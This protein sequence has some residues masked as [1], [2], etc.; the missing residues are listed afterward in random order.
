MWGG[1]RGRICGGGPCRRRRSPALSTGRLQRTPSCSW[2]AMVSVWVRG[3][4]RPT[5]LPSGRSSSRT[6]FP[7]ASSSRG[8]GCQRQQG[9]AG[10][11]HPLHVSPMKSTASAS[12]GRP[13][14][15]GGSRCA[16]STKPLCHSARS[17]RSPDEAPAAAAGA[18]PDAGAEPAGPC[19]AAWTGNSPAEPSSSSPWQT[20]ADSCR[21]NTC[22]T[23]KAPGPFVRNPGP[24][25]PAPERFSPVHSA[26]GG[27]GSRPAGTGRPT[28]PSRREGPAAPG[29]SGPLTAPPSPGWTTLAAL[30][31]TRT[32]GAAAG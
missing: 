14:S 20:Q 11:A 32:S 27:A 24:S 10:K 9:W 18:A 28:A 30:Q 26:T 2:K 1:G 23:R 25:R 6:A 21:R 5:R 29:P 7:G 3:A 13:R 4:C 8:G 17:A 12:A 31:R 15:C 19:A 22:L 16:C